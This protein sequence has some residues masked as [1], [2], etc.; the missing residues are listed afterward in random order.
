VV[1][2]WQHMTVGGAHDVPGKWAVQSSPGVLGAPKSIIGGLF[3]E[4]TLVTIRDRFLRLEAQGFNADGS[5]IGVLD[6]FEI[7]TDPGPD[8]DGDSLRDAWETA[9]NLDPLSAT[10]R[11]GASGDQDGDGQS[12]QAESIAG[13]RPD[14]PRSALTLQAVATDGSSL[15]LNWTSVPGKRYGVS[16]SQDL[17]GWSRLMDGAQPLVITAADGEATRHTLPLPGPGNWYARV[18]VVP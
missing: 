13:T 12:N 16:L 3:N 17:T 15:E 7:G 8:S 14:D 9:H 11:N 2:D 10:G 6:S 4:Y 5:S 18:H 1:K